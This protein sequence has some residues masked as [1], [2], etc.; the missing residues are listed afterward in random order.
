MTTRNKAGD[1]AALFTDPHIL[2]AAKAMALADGWTEQD[3][4]MIPS[5]YSRKFYEQAQ[6]GLAAAHPEL[7][8]TVERQQARLDAVAMLAERFVSKPRN[9]MDSIEQPGFGRGVRAAGG[10]IQA[11]LDG[12]TTHTF[13]TEHL[14]QHQEALD[15]VEALCAD[16]DGTVVT[17]ADGE[18]LPVH[19]IRTAAKL[20][21]V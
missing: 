3:W 19:L 17:Q 20:R 14:Q 21:T 4:D 16:A 9:A 8:A 11:A 5:R 15:R 1:N 7:L 2:A 12:P 6:A 18:H 13:I 10:E